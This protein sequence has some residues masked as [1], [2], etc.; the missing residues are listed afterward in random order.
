MRRA[1]T[2]IQWLE[3]SLFEERERRRRA[4]TEYTERLKDVIKPTCVIL[5]GSVARGTD[6]V[7]SDLDVVVISGNL[8]EKLF[9]RLRVVG[10]LKRGLS[11]SIDAFPYTE[12]EFERMVESAHLTALDSLHSGIPLHGE[13]Y[14]QKL[15]VRF[16]TLVALQGWRR[17]DHGWVTTPQT[18]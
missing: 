10:R 17:T 15:K 5:F 3:P 16:N 8:P 4:L 1:D 7:W 12:A 2:I 18:S 11:A 6:K 14:F 13:T 9:D